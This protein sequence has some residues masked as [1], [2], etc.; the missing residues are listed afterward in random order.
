MFGVNLNVLIYTLFLSYQT[1]SVRTPLRRVKTFLTTRVKPPS[2][3]WVELIAGVGLIVEKFEAMQVSQIDLSAGAGYLSCPV[4]LLSSNGSVCIKTLTGLPAT[5]FS[6]TEVAVSTT[7][8][9]KSS[10]LRVHQISNKVIKQVPDVALLGALTLIGTELVKREITKQSGIFPPV[11]REFANKTFQ[12]LD[13]KLE[14]LTSLE[15]QVDPFFQS[16]YRALQLQPVEAIDKYV[17]TEVVGRLEKELPSI[18]SN[19]VTEEKTVQLITSKLLELVK[20]VALMILSPTSFASS[21]SSFPMVGAFSSLN[22]LMN[23]TTPSSDGEIMITKKSLGSSSWMGLNLKPTTAAGTATVSSSE[24]V[25]PTQSPAVQVPVVSDSELNEPR[26]NLIPSI[27]GSS[28][29]VI[30]SSNTTTSIINSVR[31]RKLRDA[32]SEWN[33]IIEDLGYIAESEGLMQQVFISVARILYPNTDSGSSLYPQLGTFMSS[34]LSASN[35]TAEIATDGQRSQLM[36]S[37]LLVPFQNKL[38][39]NNNSTGIN[40][41]NIDDIYVAGS[42]RNN[43]NTNS[44]SKRILTTFNDAV[45]HMKFW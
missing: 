27:T 8:A 12:E 38:L 6:E 28:S 33:R 15:Y 37:S 20:L 19:F 17:A 7:S 22:S 18:L 9:E 34:F 21:S 26:A 2:I 40:S 30:M 1:F 32:G 36:W 14:M 43:N 25:E 13:A 3:N 5:G 23:R 35:I 39:P 42:I 31:V 45:K 41:S 16:E 4:P 11:M 44:N 10:L 24:L 29:N